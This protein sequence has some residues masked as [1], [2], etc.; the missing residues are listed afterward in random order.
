MTGSNCFK[1]PNVSGIFCFESY[2]PPLLFDW[3][4]IVLCL[5]SGDFSPGVFDLDKST[6]QCECSPFQMSV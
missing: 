5:L 2:C 6:I 4:F 1:E 3:G